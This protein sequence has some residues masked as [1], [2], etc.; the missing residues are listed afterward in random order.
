MAEP[1]TIDVIIQAVNRTEAGTKAASKAV[2]SVAEASK[3]MAEETAKAEESAKKT[4]AGF[5]QVEKSSKKVGKGLDD[6]EKSSKKAGKGL[7]DVEKSS[8]RTKR[9]LDET[10]K[11]SKRV[12]KTLR[13]LA[14]ERV[15]I[16]MEARDRF[17]PVLGKVQGGLRNLTKGAWM[18]P[19]KVADYATRP[20]RGILNL[21]SS[22]QGM[23][24]GAAGT[25][26]GLVA[27]MDISGDYEQTEIAFSTM[28][29]SQEKAKQFLADASD[30][31]NAT[32]FEF[33]DLIDS[34]KLLLA[35]GFDSDR[36]LPMMTTIGDTA[37]GLGAGAQ[38]IDR[39]NRALGQMQ[40]KGRVLT[41][42]L[43]QLQEIGIPVNQILQEELGLTQ[44]QIARIGDENVKA[45]DAI[46]GLLRGMEKRYGGMMVNQSK[47]AKGLMSTIS[48][49]FQ[50][51]FM[52]SWGTGLWAG[53]KPGLKK[54][55]GWLD[56]NPEKV[57]GLA[58][59][60]ESLGAAFSSSVM[61]V[62][63]KVR[64]EISG[65]LHDPAW[66]Q[67]DFFGKVEIAWDR[68]ILEPFSKWWDTKGREEITDTADD[69]GEFIGTGLNR[70]ILA[71]L[72]VENDGLLGDGMSAGAAFA[73]GFIDGFDPERVKTALLEAVKGI[74][75][76][77]A[78]G[79]G[80]SNTSWLS[81]LL[82]G[83]AGLKGIGI[84]AEI[85]AG[86]Y[87]TFSTARTLSRLF[88]PVD[89]AAPA[90]GG[91][92]G[93]GAAAGVFSLP[94][95]ASATSGILALLGLNASVKDLKQAQSAG[96]SWDKARY[97]RQGITK[98]G[99]VAAGAGIGTMIAP[100]VG[101][102][103]GAGV[104]GFS[105]LVGGDLLSGLFKTEREQAHEEL[106]QLGDDLEE[107]VKGYEETTERTKFGRGL[108]DQYR[109]LQ[110]YMNS[111]SF[112]ATKAE[113][114]QGRMKEVLGELQ[115]MFPELFSGYE[116]LN[117]LSAEYLDNLT[118]SLDRMDETAI[119]EME[120]ER[121]ELKDK[122][123]LMEQDY[124]E[125]QEVLQSGQIQWDKDKT[126]R[127]MLGE[128]LREYHQK[129][130]QPGLT[131][132]EEIALADEYT[133]K[134]N[135]AARFS[136]YDGDFGWISGAENAYKGLVDSMEETRSNM[137]AANQEIQE[138]NQQ[139]Q[140]YYDTSLKLIQLDT[141]VD[142]T[143]QQQ[144]IAS[145]QEVYNSLESGG[146]LTDE[147]KQM[148]EEILPGFSEAE[149]A[150][151][152][153]GMLSSGIQSLKE[154]LQ[155]ALQQIQ[156]LNRELGLLPEE[157]KIQISVE[158]NIGL[159]GLS[160][161]QG[162][163][164]AKGLSVEKHATG[165]FVTGP[166][167]SWIGEDGP[168]AVIP[169]SGKYRSRGMELYEK[170]GK[171]LGIG[172]HADGGI[173]NTS[174]SPVVQTPVSGRNS[175]ETVTVQVSAPIQIQGGTDSQAVLE[176]FQEKWESIG[177]RLLEELAIRIGRARENMQGGGVA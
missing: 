154:E 24:F 147:M 26:G 111:D 99:M 117:D 50:N 69:M 39:I 22:V 48:D 114:V 160:V 85:G 119:R 30:F 94:V 137:D 31:A 152:K 113:A 122:L 2:N 166:H 84:G 169:L 109:E 60:L 138:M 103:I 131:G 62:A 17:S 92:T 14:K 28:L 32:P 73:E 78:F 91:A 97:M 55:T 96:L 70:G 153:M 175:G 90:V 124:A 38:G 20:I 13:E 34:S 81:T 9:G 63:D 145:L 176:Q 126:Y 16:L 128:V 3:K 104:G 83:G 25:F 65:L 1:V 140:T 21:L 72:G 23:V 141:G 27:P 10:E 115:A 170:A 127:E 130:E 82:V 41:E 139:L 110:E 49:T 12:Q 95:L 40:A 100:G 45:E 164:A 129:L 56:E 107:A 44:E 161:K 135:D 143:D 66:Q 61:G 158:E 58:V 43:M 35:F 102:L 4:D 108:I 67:T 163:P 11:S 79:G 87:H 132:D 54:I 157:K 142:L 171:Y 144:K 6:V 172:Y 173:Y 123:P 121:L 29:K 134:A 177:D 150:S 88:R 162:L 146:G 151:E 89:V 168:E 71:I 116:N 106:L 51:T 7:D 98:G 101:T 46:D 136:G 37:S 76:D 64:Q 120:A 156:E 53:F 8:N 167:L 5:A 105:A 33:P 159:L 75:A 59:S 86:A 77:S 68:L 80:K 52:R 133:K 47:T 18:V 19:I 74:F 125:A 148:V 149:T 15:M 42:E 174:G 36:I 112:D 93:G 57:K 118:K 155:P 165:G